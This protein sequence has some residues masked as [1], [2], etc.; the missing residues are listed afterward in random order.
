MGLVY[1]MSDLKNVLLRLQPRALPQEISVF[2]HAVFFREIC[3]IHTLLQ[4]CLLTGTGMF[5]VMLHLGEL[6]NVEAELMVKKKV[7]QILLGKF[8]SLSKTL[9]ENADKQITQ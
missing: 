7:Y 3:H 1:G 2:P 8:F 4:S 5:L 9:T 6:L